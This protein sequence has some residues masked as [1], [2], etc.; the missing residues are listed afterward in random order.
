[1]GVAILFAL[2]LVEAGLLIGGLAGWFDRRR[3]APVVRIGVFIV[4]VLLV[5][6]NVV[7]W[8]PRYYALAV[9]LLIL[10]VWGWRGLYREPRSRTT[11]RT[12]VIGVTVAALTFLAVSPALIFPAY[13]P[14]DPTGDLPFVTAMYTVTDSERVDPFS[15][16]GYP[17]WLT[18]QAWYPDV[19]DGD[20]PLIVFS[21][22]S[23]GIKTSNQSM[24]E[25]LASHGY[26][27][28][29][30][31]HTW[32]ALYS[33]DTTGHQIW[34]DGGYLG[35]LRAENAR[36]D[37]E[38]SLQYYRKWM[39]VRVEDIDFVLDQVL[40][41]DVGEL[42]DP[43]RI[44]LIGHSLGGAAVLGV[45][46]LRDDI[47]AVIALEAPYMTEI[48]DVVDGRFVWNPD[49]YPVPV[50]NVYS[51]SAWGHLD[52]WPQYGRNREMLDD[53]TVENVH[54]E[55]VGHLHLTDLSLS[56]PF[57][58]RVLNGH[59]SSGDAR[60]ALTELNGH[61]LRFF[62]THLKARDARVPYIGDVI[63]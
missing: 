52:E 20:F 12:V 48:V 54:I 9:W 62:D 63:P 43:D 18:L 22:G 13:T 45:G 44:G 10:A 21:H 11:G 14:I 47:D 51:D 50:L 6:T 57:L 17:R 38:Q 60:E 4:F 5:A 34:I 7:D 31:D 39:G 40:D 3:V 37:P 19:T 59:P 53:P 2:L 15:K 1:M 35:E 41:A 30:I 33:S 29:S 16:H 36:E 27:V 46:R 8:A 32:H 24:F 49:S 42:T 28:V 56:S 58:T 26:V 25:D 23:M 55:D 61:V